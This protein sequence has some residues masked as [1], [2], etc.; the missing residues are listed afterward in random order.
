MVFKE[1]I[2]QAAQK[3]DFPLSF[4]CILCNDS[5]INGMQINNLNLDAALRSLKRFLV[6]LPGVSLVLLGCAVLAAEELVRPILSIFLISFGLLAVAI[7][8]ALLRV[9]R[10]V[11]LSFDMIDGQLASALYKRSVLQKLRIILSSV[12]VPFNSELGNEAVTGPEFT[13]A[14][15]DAPKKDWYH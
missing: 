13:L 8:F 14:A 6:L 10:E 15:P 5:G 3:K 2:A 7:T 12:N 1:G 9:G 4:R 11:A